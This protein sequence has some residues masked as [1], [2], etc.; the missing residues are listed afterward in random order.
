MATSPTLALPL[1]DL[2]RC[3]GCGLCEERC[4]TCAVEVRN[5][6]AQIVRPADCTCCDVCDAYCPEGAIGRSFTIV[7]AP[8]LEL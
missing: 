5:R 2:S 3:T 6:Q 8:R 4:P 7:F 1:I